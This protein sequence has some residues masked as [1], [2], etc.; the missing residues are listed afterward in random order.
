MLNFR[1]IDLRSWMY[2]WVFLLLGGVASIVFGSK[3]RCVWPFRPSS[4][5][6]LPHLKFLF[7]YL[8]N[9]LV[10]LNFR[11]IGWLTRLFLASQLNDLVSAGMW[12]LEP[13]AL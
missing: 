3:R 12:K 11:L 7:V 9:L 2:A 4:P 1:L 5:L 8:T 10:L 13:R 6:R